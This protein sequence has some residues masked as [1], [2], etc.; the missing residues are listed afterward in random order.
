MN[1]ISKYVLIRFYVLQYGVFDP[2]EKNL[3]TLNIE[4]TLYAETS[5]LKLYTAR[6]TNPD[7]LT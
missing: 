4:A 2:P 3:V 6:Y 7:I 1:N 5:E